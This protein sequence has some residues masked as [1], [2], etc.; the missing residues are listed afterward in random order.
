MS[1]QPGA[2]LRPA[3]DPRL[4]VELAGVPLRNPVLAAAGTFGWGEEYR[5]FVDPAR[6]GGIV[7]KGVAPVPWPGNPAPRLVE[8]P[9]GLL[10][11]I[12]LENPGVER[13][14][15]DYL[16]RL[17]GLGT[18]I[19]VN[20]VGKSPEEYA[21]V[22]ARLDGQPGLA[23]LELNVSCPNVKEGGLAF[24][25]RPEGIAAV[26][27]AVR[28]VTS[29]PLIVKLSPNVADIAAL[30]RAAQEAGADAVSLIN[31]LAGMVIDV[32]R[33][34]PVLAT[35]VG[36]L[37]GP[38]IRPVAVRMVWEVAQAV[39][40]PIVG[41]GGIT[42]AQDALEFILAG[43]TAVAVGTAGFIRPTALV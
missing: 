12:G 9:A 32:R 11:S 1:T 40:I 23:G 41:G 20:V 13:F 34:R 8:T 15:A 25:T 31:T 24:G 27:R 36:G 16:P 10:N 6:L 4:V 37:S 38:A 29:L 5:P 2:H 7:V 21:Q 3:P 28:P 33:R 22:A 17:Q 26:V 30:A 19:F 42:S 43:A 14:I 35:A 18:R 39:T